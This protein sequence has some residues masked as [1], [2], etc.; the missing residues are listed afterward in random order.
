MLPGVVKADEGAGLFVRGGDVHETRTLVDRAVLDHPYRYE[1]TNGGLFGTV[2]PFLITG[3]SLSAG[4]FPARYGDALSG[5]LELHGLER[6]ESRS[7]LVTVGLA[8]ASAQL[9]LPVGR[10]AGLRLSGNQ[11]FT[12]L[13]FAVNRPE[14]RFERHPAGTDLNVGAYYESRRLGSLQASFFR[15]SER[16]G[17]EVEEEAFRGDLASESDNEL[18]SLRWRRP[19]LG[20]ALAEVT[21][22][23]T[24]YREDLDVGAITLAA[25]D[26]GRRA[27]LDVT[28]SW[29]G[30]IVRLGAESERRRD[31]LEGTASQRGG[32]FAGVS[33]ARAWCLD[34]PSA[35]DGGYVELERSTSR[36]DVNVGFRADHYATFG[37]WVSDPRASAT[38]RLTGPH[39]I[40][41]AWGRYHQAPSA[42]YLD[43]EWGNPRLG[44]MA[45]RHLVLGYGLGEPDDRFHLRVETYDKRYSGLP[46]EDPQSN[47]TD[48]GTGTARGVDV[49][50]RASGGEGWD[51]WGSYGFVRARRRSTRLADFG[52]Y[53]TPAVPVRPDFEIPHTLQ[54]AARRALPRA[55]T[56]TGSF[57]LASGKPFTPIVSG[58]ERDGAVTPVY[59]ALNSERTPR[60]QRLDVALSQIRPVGN[61]AAAVWFVGITNVLGR[62]NVFG[63]SYSPDFRTR[64]PRRSSFGRT[65]YFGVSFQR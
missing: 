55:F 27:R 28:T 40:R 48:D 65:V 25:R 26:R 2:P 64:S 17:V 43:A 6:P 58:V 44:V 37:R 3:V 50:V 12:G 30:T 51:A 41:L 19:L 45:A 53:D 61:A 29:G 49:F 52:R 59:G 9:S 34:F 10:R 13:L 7:S 38:L 47:Y 63:Y 18:A 21:L 46:V 22:S 31:A 32:D 60:Y 5:V 11:S 23:Q 57:R 24:R 16:V 33:G 42:G 36:V 56:L 4:G 1:S 39:R 54:L 8:A 20:R 15:A 62:R 14:Q 35:R